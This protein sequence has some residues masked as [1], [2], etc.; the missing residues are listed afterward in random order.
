MATRHIKA[1]VYII[2]RAGTAVNPMIIKL[3]DIM[4][5][6]KNFIFVGNTRFSPQLVKNGPNN[7]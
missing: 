7:G 4:A 1:A 5:N 3:L 2:P 6:I